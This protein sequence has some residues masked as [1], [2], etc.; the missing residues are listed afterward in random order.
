MVR[1]QGLGPTSLTCDLLSALGRVLEW[2]SKKTCP[3]GL[4]WKVQDTMHV[5]GS[6]HH[7]HSPQAHGLG[8]QHS[9]WE[10]LRVNQR[11]CV[12]LWQGSPVHW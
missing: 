4:T 3:T 6:H 12:L 11:L 8:G 7:W 5:N 10:A 9:L 2:G 1:T